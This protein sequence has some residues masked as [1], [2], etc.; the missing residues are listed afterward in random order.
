MPQGHLDAETKRGG[1]EITS[2]LLKAGALTSSQD[3]LS[4]MLHRP[5]TPG[6]DEEIRTEADLLRFARDL[7]GDGRLPVVEPRRRSD[8]FLRRCLTPP[9][10]S[11]ALKYT[12]EALRS[13][14]V[15]GITVG[16]ILIPQGMAYAMLAELPPIY[17]LYVALTPLP[18]YGMLCTSRHLSIGPFALVSLLVADTVETVYD[19][20]K[21][22]ELYIRAVMTVSLM[23]G[24]MHIIMGTQLMCTIRA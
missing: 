21:E 24:V 13:D 15:A 4:T 17:G 23:V 5:Q 16:V 20:D 8:G 9:F 6:H 7:T 2:G 19:S 12:Q 3:D 11:W 18:I 10:L 1:D 14:L 22:P